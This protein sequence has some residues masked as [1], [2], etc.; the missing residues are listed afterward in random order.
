MKQRVAEKRHARSVGLFEAKV[1]HKTDAIVDENVNT[2]CPHFSPQTQSSGSESTCRCPSCSRAGIWL[3]TSRAAVDVRVVPFLKCRRHDNGLCFRERSSSLTS[4]CWMQEVSVVIAPLYS[5]GG[6]INGFRV[7]GL[8]IQLDRPGKS[9]WT[10]GS[11]AAVEN[12]QRCYME[13]CVYT[14]THFIAES[15]RS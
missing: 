4:G 13:M 2:Y 8:W 7:Q 14:H 6:V 12:L 11:R 10:M 1:G 5:P 9:Q 15:I 3:K